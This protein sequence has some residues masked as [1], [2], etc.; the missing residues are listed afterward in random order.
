MTLVDLNKLLVSILQKTSQLKKRFINEKLGS[1]DYVGI[2]PKNSENRQEFTSLIKSL[3]AKVAYWDDDGELYQITIPIKTDFGE[4]KLIK[5]CRENSIY[6]PKS[7]K[8]GYVDYQVKNYEILKEKYKNQIPFTFIYGNGREILSLQEPEF[9]VS[10][11]I[12]NIPLS[13][14]LGLS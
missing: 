2:F 11:Y 10:V 4:I 9:D 5:V 6:N 8:I 3:D 7:N 12:P 14:D 1:I 13:K